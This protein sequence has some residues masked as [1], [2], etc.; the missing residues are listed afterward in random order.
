MNK[1]ITSSLAVLLFLTLSATRIFADDLEKMAGKWSLAHTNDNGL[2]Y[3]QSLE[4]V[5]GKF[6]FQVTD[7]DK[8]VVLYAKGDVKLDKLGELK[9]ASF[10]HIEGGANS[11]DLNPVDDDRH[12]V[13]VLDGDSLTLAM[14]FD[15]DREK[16]PRIDV[17]T[18]GK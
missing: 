7:S 5:K 13:Y 1:L 17:Y 12:C 8:K 14:N 6:V 18:R 3:T 15:R 10:I 9:G 2:T 4:I 11:D 16:G